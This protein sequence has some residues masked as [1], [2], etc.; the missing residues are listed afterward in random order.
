MLTDPVGITVA[1][2]SDALPIS[3]FDGFL[4]PMD[5]WYLISGAPYWLTQ[6]TPTQVHQAWA[7]NGDGSRVVQPPVLFSFTMDNIIF[8][9]P[10]DNNYAGFLTYYQQ[11][12]ALSGTNPVN[13]LTVTYP[14]L[15][16]CACMAAACE[17]AKDNGQGSFDRTYWDALAQDEI[18]K[19]QM[20]S[21]R[22]RRGI[23]NAGVLI[24]GGGIGLPM[25]AGS[26]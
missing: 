23:E 15:M 9:S 20:E 19:A 25:W 5:L 3:G 1:Q 18:D 21:D 11:L 2:N 12:D 22:A 26:W 16:R 7:Y 6:K 17:W 14:R 13:F 8:D 24:G 4:E 10:S